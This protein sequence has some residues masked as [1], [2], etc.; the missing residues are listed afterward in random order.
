M[1]GWSTL[2]LLLLLALATWVDLRTNRIPNAIVLAGILLAFVFAGAAAGPRGLAA[3]LAGVLVAGGCLLPFHLGGGMGAGDVKLMAMVGAFLGPLGA[4]SAVALT[5]VAGL[6]LSAAALLAT[7]AV[8]SGF[9]LR[10]LS[11][12]SARMP[13]PATEQGSAR[14]LRFP[15]AMAILLGTLVS[16][17]VSA[18]LTTAGELMG[19]VWTR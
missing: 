7:Q 19:S 14:S 13:R 8:A 10:L 12:A 9:G 3:A 6:L 5:L 11:S 15:Y 17:W 4:L 1:D 18:E 2:I 16:L